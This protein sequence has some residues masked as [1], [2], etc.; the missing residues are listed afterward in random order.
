[1]FTK[2]R[3]A[4]SVRLIRKIQQYGPHKVQVLGKTYEISKDVFNPKFY[5]TSE[6]MAQHIEVKPDDEV[7]DIGT[8]SGIQAITAGQTARKV[9]AVDISFDAVRFARQNVRANGLENIVSVLQ[10]DLF[11]PLKSEFKFTVILF[12]PP[13]FNGMPKSGFE[14]SLYDPG[15]E[16][17][18]RFLREAREYLNPDGY[19]QMV[20]SSIA[21]PD[22]VLKIA[23]GLGWKNTLTAQ[24]KT[25]MERFFIY[26]LTLN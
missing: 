7:L 5:Y 25:L 1:M 14:H 26:R 11:S 16:L 3:Q 21:E 12:T 13:Y 9:I 18:R 22:R 10:G 24:R 4:V 23:D 17:V 20:Y 15:K 8:G 6:F 19:V 2:L